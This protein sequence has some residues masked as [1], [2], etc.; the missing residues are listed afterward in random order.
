MLKGWVHL[1]QCWHREVAVIRVYV[2]RNI[3]NIKDRLI[4]I[5]RILKLIDK[6]KENFCS[7]TLSRTYGVSIF[8]DYCTALATRKKVEGEERDTGLINRTRSAAVQPGATG[9]LMACA[10]RVVLIRAPPPSHTLPKQDYS[11]ILAASAKI[12]DGLRLGA[13][14]YDS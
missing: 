14:E 3:W 6:G 12:E 11:Q 2:I 10:R 8:I 4:I 13:C 7:L 9:C 1:L 5:I